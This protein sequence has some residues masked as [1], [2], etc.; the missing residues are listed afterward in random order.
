MVAQPNNGAFVET[1]YV[2]QSPRLDFRVKFVQTGPHHVWVRGYANTL[3]DNTCHVGLDGQAV[4]TA[5]KI[6]LSAVQD[7]EWTKA[8]VGTSCSNGPPA[9]VNVSSAGVHTVNLWMRE[10]GFKVTKIIL[11]TN[12][13]YVPSDNGADPESLEGGGT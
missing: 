2:T 4:S 9:T 8:T 1:A 5:D 3:D 10:D 7:W 11:T 12:A 6:C 13:S